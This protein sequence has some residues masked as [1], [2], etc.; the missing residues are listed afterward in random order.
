MTFISS[1]QLVLKLS[2]DTYLYICSKI[3]LCSGL[4][5]VTS[6]RKFASYILRGVA[7][8]QF[9]AARV[10]YAKILYCESSHICDFLF[11]NIFFLFISYWMRIP[12]SGNQNKSI[13]SFKLF[14]CLYVFKQEKV[15]LTLFA[16]LLDYITGNNI[17]PL[18]YQRYVLDRSSEKKNCSNWMSEADFFLLI[19]FFMFCNK[20]I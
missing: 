4:R 6:M 17:N 7:N 12:R 8:R 14:L 20:S 19:I 16:N 10:L 15:F 3:M 5:N 13:S 11:A 9:M 18:N 2:S 1:T